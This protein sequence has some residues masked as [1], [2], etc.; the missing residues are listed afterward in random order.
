MLIYSLYIFTSCKCLSID[1]SYSLIILFLNQGNDKSCKFL[2][3]ILRG[4]L[5]SQRPKFRNVI[6]CMRVVENGMNEIFYSHVF[7]FFGI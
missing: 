3:S 2:D 5:S 7:T 1:R 6:K 4:L